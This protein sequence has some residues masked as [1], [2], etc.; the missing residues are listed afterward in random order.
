M[1]LRLQNDHF[2]YTDEKKTT[3]ILAIKASVRQVYEEKLKNQKPV[4]NK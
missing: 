2:A 3:R 4:T 1:F